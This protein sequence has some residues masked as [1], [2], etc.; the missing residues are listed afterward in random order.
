MTLVLL[1]ACLAGLAAAV[2]LLGPC[3]PRRLEGVLPRRTSGPPAEGL[4]TGWVRVACAVGGL[5]AWW[6][7]GGLLGMLAGAALVLVAPRAL[8]RL[9]GPKDDSALVAGQLPLVLDLLAACL[10]GGA[11]TV[12]AVR[13]VAAALPGACSDRLLRVAAALAVGS[14]PAEAWRALGEDRGPAG[15]AARALA[16]A[17]EGGAPVAAAVQRVAQDAR[18]EA[19]ARAERAA[20]RA[21]VLAVG[22]LGLCFLPAF[23]L[24]G[25]VPAI[26]GLAGPLFA[27]L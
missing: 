15:T 12:T 6:G 7:L 23:L 3:T 11:S 27:S 26:V 4:S 20:R 2:A 13:A 17:A 14:T 22:P 9:D 16:R 8:A 21:G 24:L 18:R 5:G 1:T 10:S 25:V 19:G